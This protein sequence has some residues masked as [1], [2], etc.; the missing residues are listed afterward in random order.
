MDFSEVLLQYV[1]KYYTKPHEIINLIFAIIAGLAAL[2]ATI[3]TLSDKMSDGLS[4]ILA[5]TFTPVML[6]GIVLYIGRNSP[7]E[8][9]KVLE[10]EHA[11]ILNHDIIDGFNPLK[12]KRV[13]ELINPSFTEK[14]TDDKFKEL[15]DM[16][17]SRTP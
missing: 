17:N 14:N 10:V 5:I 16:L 12:R 2:S 8:N 15:M 6:L 11:I 4:H 13:F 3:I 7:K 1:Q 9:K